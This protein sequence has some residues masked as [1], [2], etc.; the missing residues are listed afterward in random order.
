MS[1]NKIR[2]DKN[3][4]SGLNSFSGV[5]SHQDMF[6]Q[7]LASQNMT[8]GNYGKA[9]ETTP[10]VAPNQSESTPQNVFPG[11][12]VPEVTPLDNVAFLK[13][14]VGEGFEIV[15]NTVY[16]VYRALSNERIV[17]NET[18]AT[19]SVID[20]HGS[21]VKKANDAFSK[22]NSAYNRLFT[23]T[24]YLFQLPQNI[25]KNVDEA[26][27]KLREGSATLDKV[28]ESVAER[29]L[30]VPSLSYGVW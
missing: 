9:S 19:Q 27:D 8:F 12:D 7:A 6:G 13:K 2:E 22:L 5:E 24:G 26:H 14:P 15:V 17:L 29:G 11:S 20:A 25:A 16:D 4:V 10:L 30:S 18:G 21:D 3:M 28:L 1:N 23:G